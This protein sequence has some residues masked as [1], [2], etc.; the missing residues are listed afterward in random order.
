MCASSFALAA[1]IN[2]REA[3]FIVS[4]ELDA[5]AAP[6]LVAQVAGLPAAINRVRVDLGAVTFLD[7]GGVAALLHVRSALA[8]RGVLWSFDGTSEYVRW[9][10]TMARV[11]DTLGVEPL[12]EAVRWEPPGGSVA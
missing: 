5:F 8:E 2:A 4:G 9:V 10:C 12:C 1:E 3:T 7:A 11:A 6:D